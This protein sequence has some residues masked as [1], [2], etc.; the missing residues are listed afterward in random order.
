MTNPEMTKQVLHMAQWLINGMIETYETTGQLNLPDLS[1]MSALL[2]LDMPIADGVIGPNGELQPYKENGHADTPQ[3]EPQQKR[4]KRR[5]KAELDA[6]RSQ[7]ATGATGT[8][9]RHDESRQEHADG[10]P[11]SGFQEILPE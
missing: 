2:A 1:Q 10:V 4:R 6:A 11:D 8:D 5:T 3:T 9:D 7:L